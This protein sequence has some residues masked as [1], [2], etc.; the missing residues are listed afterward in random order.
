MNENF[1]MQLH[2]FTDASNVA[3]GA[4]GYVR[5]ICRHHSLSLN[6]GQIT[7]HRLW[8]NYN[9]STGA[10]SCSICSKTFEIDKARVRLAKCS[11]LLLD[12]LYYCTTKSMS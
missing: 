1:Q 8:T 4:V 3:R 2:V 11:V 6:H 9:T 7:Y 12:R 10:R 5:M